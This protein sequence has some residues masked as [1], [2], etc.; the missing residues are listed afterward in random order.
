MY[1]RS[2]ECKMEVHYAVHVQR[3]IFV[4]YASLGKVYSACSLP[5]IS[6]VFIRRKTR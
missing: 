4:Q 1:I 5:A 6:N 3:Y 2:Q